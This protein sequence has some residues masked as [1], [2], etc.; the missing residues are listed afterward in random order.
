[1]SSTYGYDTLNRLNGLANS[2]AGSFGFS[3]ACPER[4]RRNALS[5]RTQLTRPNGITTNYSYD[6]LSHLLSVLHQAGTNVLDGASYTYDPAGNRTSK[7][8]YL[9]GVT[10][11]YT[12]DALYQ[13]TQVTQG[14]STTESYSYDAVGNRLSSSG[15]PNYSYN[16]S[17]ELTSNSNGS[18]AYDANGNTLADAQGRSFTWDFENRLTQ[19]VNP[20]VGTT[21]FR[22]DPFG[23]RIQKSGPLGTVNYLY[24]GTNPIE[25]VD[26]AGNVLARYTQNSGVDQVEA[27]MRSGTTSYYLADG[28][29]TITSLSNAAGTLAQTYTFDAFGNQTAS[30]GSLTNAFRYTAREF[31]PETNLYYYRARYLDPASGRFVTEDPKR[32]QAAAN[33]YPYVSNSPT[34][35]LDP[36][37][38][39]KCKSGNC[40]GDC[41]GGRWVSGALTFEA[42][43]S[44]GPV[45]AG[46]LVF[47]GVFICTSNPTFNL[48]FY[49]LCG[50]GSGGLTPRPPLT[51]PPSKPFGG[52]VGAGGAVIT[53]TG[54]K[55][56]EDMEGVEGGGFG[57]V[58]P[59]YG[60]YEGTSSGVSCYGG[61]G[62]FDFGLSLGGFKCKTYIG[63]SWTF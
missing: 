22:Y 3:Y 1:M 10:S 41:P 16:S 14:T 11:N 15:V 34:T 27:Q 36:F 26:N 9:N 24:D 57:Q 46:G 60:F 53:C 45:N 50:F 4:S 21:T 48:P 28:L 8:N 6:S 5:R 7:G 25:E 44:A 20:G 62:G 40:P 31:D 19:V 52:G 43:G 56:R 39:S 30:S 55:C 61:G 29:G 63:N 18:Y 47:S 49:T 13:L 23:R 17:N 37:G 51:S 32:F 54:A 35:H 42:Y 59:F 58:G 38:W 33:F 2:W 12:Y